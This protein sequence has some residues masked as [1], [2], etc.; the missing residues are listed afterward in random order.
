MN[1]E[2]DPEADSMEPATARKIANQ[3]I[4][5]GIHCGKNGNYEKSKEYFDEALQVLE[6]ASEAL[7]QRAGGP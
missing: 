3:K 4:V 7:D 2:M 1:K 6:A 5:V